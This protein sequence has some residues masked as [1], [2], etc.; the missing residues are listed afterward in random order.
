MA[1]SPEK[2]APTRQRGHVASPARRTERGF[3]R[4]LF[5]SDAVVAI[6][7]SLLILPLVDIVSD[8]AVGVRD[9]LDDH[10]GQLFAFALSF[11][12]IAQYWV[13]HHK[14]FEDVTG[15]TPGIMWANLLW[16]ASIVFLPLPTEMLGNELTQSR[17]VHA[18]YI[19]A[20]LISS[21]TL[22]LLHYVLSRHPDLY[23]RRF[24]PWDM[25]T[26]ATMAVALVIAVAVPAIGMWSMVLV[27]LS[28]PL[29]ARVERRRDRAPRAA[30]VE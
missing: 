8:D 11:V 29:Q 4:M 2:D 12:V 25:T 24:D 27:T 19:G 5:F 13:V 18:L 30:S 14:L 10:G 3:E 6:A 9:L 23:G 28:G 1:L 7:I 16:L 26:T 15:Y 22:D 17:A 21:A 20:V